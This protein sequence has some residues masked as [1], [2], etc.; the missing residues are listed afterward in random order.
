MKPMIQTNQIVILCV[1]AL[2]TG[3]ATDPKNSTVAEVGPGRLSTSDGDRQG[4]LLVHSA[5]EA[6]M[7]APEQ[8]FHSSYKILSAD[9]ALLQ[10][11]SNQ[12]RNY[13]D[14]EPVSLPPGRYSV[15]ARARNYG[16][17][18]VPVVIEAGKTTLVHLDSCNRPVS[19]DD[20]STDFV[21]LPNGQFIG[22]KAAA[23]K[24]NE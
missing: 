10:T 9:G 24:N 11:V 3:C 20:P 4:I 15:V 5:R 6:S 7:N 14:P 19:R 22:W 2:I 16:T 23:G 8:R 12:G 17:L 13:R 18:T 21:R 1:I